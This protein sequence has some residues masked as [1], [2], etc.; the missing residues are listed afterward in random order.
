MRNL[1][2][3]TL[4]IFT[5]FVLSAQKHYPVTYDQLK[6]YEGVYEYFNHA[7]IKIAASPVDTILYGII[8]QSS[9][10]LRPV[11]KDIVANNLSQ[12]TKFLRNSS[13]T[14]TG[15]ATG[16]DT[17]KLIT[18]NI[19]FP[20]QMWYPRSRADLLYY[21][22]KYTIPPALNDGLPTGDA[23]RAGLDTGLLA[24]M[25]NKI[26]TAKYLNVHGILIIKDG[27][28]VFEEYF[29]NYGRDSL[30]EQRSAT[31]S[32]VSALT[33]IAIHQG[34]IKSVNE[35]VLSYFPEYHLDNNSE[36]KQRITVKDLLSNQ[37]GLNYDEAYDKAIGNENTMSY[38][39]DWVKYTLD[40]PMLDTP[41]TKGRY[42]SGNPITVARIIEKATQMPLHDFAAK[43]LYGPM[44]IT[45]FKWN[46][47]PDK[48]GAENYGEVFLRPRDMAKF[49]LLYLN[50]G[51]WN[52]QQLVPAEWVKESTSKQSVVQ[53]V[54]YGYLWWLKYL[55]AD[56][57]VRY[58]SFA[59]QGNGGQKIYVFK[60][61]Q[62][63]VVV[64]GGNYNTQS[65]SN[66]L[67][68]KYILPAFNKK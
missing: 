16:K 66:E 57:G 15:Y 12:R 54:D 47:T 22:Y 31:K 64:T 17:F 20:A 41:G 42:A 62:L 43:N 1:F 26:V 3:A 27:K 24:A 25:M 65:P 18:R 4:F 44:G 60:Q 32:A 40:L 59:A 63:V 13:N 58:Y 14:I 2:F 28:L 45:N 19:S 39:D 23:A 55:D 61:Q 37:S 38:T 21:H 49:G 10:A 9:Y 52:K 36:L 50:N 7:T 6:E 51:V 8:N 29:Y 48:R 5:T 11:D 34:Y 67:I 35:K 30:Q 53:G 68:K 56:G 46:F 33:G